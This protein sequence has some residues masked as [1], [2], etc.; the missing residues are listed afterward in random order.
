PEKEPDYPLGLHQNAVLRF[1]PTDFILAAGNFKI[2]LPPGDISVMA[3]GEFSCLGVSFHRFYLQDLK[4]A[5]WVLEAAR[6]IRQTPVRDGP[7]PG[8]EAGGSKHEVELILFQT[9]DEVYPDDWDFWLNERTGL[10]GYKDFHTP[11]QIEYYRVYPNPG[12]DWSSP[13]EFEESVRGCGENFLISHA[14]MLYSRAI[15]T[16]AGGELTEYL[17]VS[18]EEDEEGVLVRIM[19]GV[20]LS[21]MSLTVL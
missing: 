3:V 2:D 15:D 9:I 20:P 14:M 1:D 18:R 12:P 19:A 17:M 5:E 21:P 16:A 7:V 10:I 4:E 8:R 13:I 11:D 6:S